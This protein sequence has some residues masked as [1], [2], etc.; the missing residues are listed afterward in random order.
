M[1]RKGDYDRRLYDTGGHYG[2]GSGRMFNV[3]VVGLSGTEKDKGALGVGKSCLCNRF[4]RPQADEYNREHISVLSQP[5]FSGP[6][7]NNEHWLYWGETRKC[8]EEGFELTFSVVEQTEFV[9][10]AC[11]QPFRSGKTMELYHKRCAATKLSSAEKLMYI[12]KNQLGVEK[13]YEQHYLPDGKFSVDG[14]VCVF[15]VSEIQGRSIERQV[16]LTALILNSLM[17]TKKPVVL[18]TTKNDEVYEPFVRE[19]EKLVSRKEYKGLIP[20]VET[21]AHEGVNVDLAFW[22]CIQRDWTKG[23]TK[24][25]SYQDAS[26]KQQGRL[27]LVNDAYL[28]LIRSQITDYRFVFCFFTFFTKEKLDQYSNLSLSSE[29]F[30]LNSLLYRLS[31]P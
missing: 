1:S 14:F 25:P 12:C 21:S 31:F 2:G 15:D 3:V 6:I 9:D 24:I 5:D 30:S 22:A 26:M 28:T 16:E 18:V 23:K 10:D 7:V 27:E 19:A 8:T 29:F 20:L 4:L 11:F 13:E 17:K